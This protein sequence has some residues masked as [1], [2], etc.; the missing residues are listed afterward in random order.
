LS[1][2]FISYRRNDSQGEAGRLFDDLV[3]RFDENT[4]FMDVAAIEAGRDFRKAI[5][6][7]VTK[8]GV[9]LVVIGLEWLTAKDERAGRRLDD[10]GDF[11]RIETAAALKRDIP[12]I[13]VL[14]RGAKMPTAEQLPEDLKELAFR[15]CV[16]LSHVRW[17]SDIQLLIEALRRLPGIAVKPTTNTGQAVKL[18]EKPASFHAGESPATINPADIERVSR[19]LAVRI[20]PIA[21]VVVKRAAA[22]CASVEDLYL[23]VAEEIDSREERE[24][25]LRHTSVSSTPLPEAV[26][27]GTAISKTAIGKTTINK[28][29]INKTQIEPSPS[30]RAENSDVPSKTTP[31]LARAGRPT[32][33]KY[34][35]IA[36]GIGILLVLLILLLWP[37]LHNK[38]YSRTAQTSRPEDVAKDSKTEATPPVAIAAPP[39]KSDQSKNVETSGSAEAKNAQAKNDELKNERPKLPQRV[40]VP[41]EVSSGLL[42]REV[43]PAYPPL[44][45]Q[46]NIRG[47]VVLDVDISSDGVV[48]SLRMVK[49]HPMLVPAAIEAVK[50]WRYKPFML[51]DQPTPISTQVGVNFTLK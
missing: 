34:G 7:G 2:I 25:F 26:G 42:V 8:C 50:Q 39:A 17:K 15:N 49:G 9:L 19:E 18:P 48:Q 45:R 12:V 47:M 1:G 40:R 21:F 3:Q 13:P 10:P 14:V 22:I 51:N 46:A 5:E 29:T 23:K 20:G 28:T 38:P 16:E 43:Q 41:P 27:A 30:A 35:L 33:S 32:T 11:V 37:A 4:V 44:A 24:R 36:C 6:E 31:A